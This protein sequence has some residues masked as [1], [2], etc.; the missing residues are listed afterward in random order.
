MRLLKNKA[1]LITGAASGLGFASAW[2]LASEGARLAL[3]DRQ[4]ALLHA[5]REKIAAA[6]PGVS[7]ITVTADVSDEAQVE[8][9]VA[10]TLGAFGR[11]D[12]F[13]NNAG[14]EGAQNETQNYGSDDFDEVIRIN[15]NG[16]F[17]GLK[18]VLPVMRKQGEGSVVN[19]AS[20]AGLRGLGG[21]PGYA[22]SKHGVIGLT[23]NAAME[24]AA[25]G[26]VVNAIA[27]GVIETPMVE[28]TLKKMNPENPEQAKETM[29]AHN[30]AAR[31]G[32]PE[33]VAGVVAFLLSG[34]ASFV[35]A[36]VINIDGG[37][38]FRY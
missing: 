37:Q 19:T 5:A 16:V 23:R 21:M 6:F 36:A 17:Y 7:V 34:D 28:S 29:L 14:I 15:L 26:I 20:V 25:Y 38:S 3:V 11:I 1:V 18:H 31:M 33:E 10:K 24:N 22:A 27:P 13:F 30:P 32:Q 4:E 35:N 8:N 2:R 9:Y 12:G